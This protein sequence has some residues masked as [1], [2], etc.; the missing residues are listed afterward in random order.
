MDAMLATN[1]VSDESPYPS[2]LMEVG[3][4]HCFQA[5][6]EMVRPKIF[7]NIFLFRSVNL[8]IKVLFSDGLVV[9]RRKVIF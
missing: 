9:R 2:P 7:V 1:A 6:S 4:E 5:I 8:E 3:R